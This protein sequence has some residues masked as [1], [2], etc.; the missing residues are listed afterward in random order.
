MAMGIAGWLLGYHFGRGL[1]YPVYARLI[2]RISVE[3]AVAKYESQVTKRLAANFK[4]SGLNGY[5][6]TINII[7]IKDEKILEV[8]TENN[9]RKS[10]LIK[11]YPFTGFSGKL[12]PKL[13]EGD[14]QIPEGI[15]NISYLNPNSSY[16]LSM[17]VSYPNDFDKAMATLD[18]RTNLGGDIMIHGKNGTIGCIP[19]GDPAIEELFVMVQ[20]AKIENVKVIIAPTDFRKGRPFPEITAVSW[21]DKLYGKIKEELASYK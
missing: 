19:L 10:V 3:Q 5:P 20:K 11:T 9:K 6:N 4:R 12:G 17:K 8:R 15:Y 2:G 13:Q 18:R 21:S 14:R 1:W 7:A 16:H